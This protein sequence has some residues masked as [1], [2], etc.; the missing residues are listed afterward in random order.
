M[1]GL[2]GL[3]IPEGSIQSILDGRG[4]ISGATPLKDVEKRDADLLKAD[5]YVWRALSPST[6]QSV[7]DS[8]GFWKHREGGY[9]QTPSDKDR[10]LRAANS[11]YEM[12]GEETVAVRSGIRI[13]NF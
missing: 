7:E 11:I 1:Q 2:L 8:D 10:L 4:G 6:G 3:N 5:L 12:Y 9:S 13:F